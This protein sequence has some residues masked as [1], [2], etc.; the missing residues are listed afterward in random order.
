MARVRQKG[1]RCEV[2]LRRA[3]HSRGL[4][5]RLQV[6]LITKPRRFADVVFVS[7]RVAVFVDGCFWHGCPEHASWLKTNAEFSR[8]KFKANRSWDADTGR[9]LSELGWRV[10]RIWEHEDANDAADRIAELILSTKKNGTGAC[11]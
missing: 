6:P 7:A 3:L 2:E 11:R 4:R 10:I 1:R 9:R 8:E 5:Y